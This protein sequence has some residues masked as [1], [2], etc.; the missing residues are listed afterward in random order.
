MTSKMNDLVIEF[1]SDT[2]QYIKSL[3]GFETQER[4][5]EAINILIE[6]IKKQDHLIKKDSRKEYLGKVIIFSKGSVEKAKL[7]YDNMCKFRTLLPEYFEPFDKR[8]IENVFSCLLPKMT[9]D[10]CRVYLQKTYDRRFPAGF[11]D[12]FKFLSMMCEYLQTYDYCNSLLVVF[13]Y[14]EANLEDIIKNIN[15]VEEGYGFRIKGIHILSTSKAIDFFLIILK[16]AL[17]PKI[18]QRIHIHTK[19]ET[20]YKHIPNEIL[21]LEYGGNE[22]SIETLSSNLMDAL[23][24]KEF[25]EYYNTTK[26]Y[27][28]N[29]AYRN[30]GKVADQMGLEGTF[31]KL[32]ID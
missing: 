28:T 31:R 16:K 9:K 20:L 12:Y 1:N 23:A 5:E 2:V 25:Q 17:S 18:A 30:K 19:I 14:F 3:Y 26:Q 22:K 24:S 4:F 11:L 6:W 8:N 32:G 10:H 15:I 7:K 13:D 21:P 27:R 29:E